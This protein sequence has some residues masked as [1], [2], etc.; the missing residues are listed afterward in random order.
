[1]SG[2][3][4][5]VAGSCYRAAAGCL[6]VLFWLSCSPDGLRAYL[7]VAAGHQ[8]DYYREGA[9][10]CSRGEKEGGMS[11]KGQIRLHLGV[12]A[13]VAYGFKNVLSL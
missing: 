4:W 3:E 8:A 2:R 10:H 7:V 6:R 1:M 5:P 12:R 11:V 9:R 13:L